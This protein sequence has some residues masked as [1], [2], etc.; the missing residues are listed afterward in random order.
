[1]WLNIFIS[2]L[3]ILII[4]IFYSIRD[5]FGHEL[6][7]DFSDNSVPLMKNAFDVVR[8]NPGEKK[9][10]V[11][12]K[13]HSQ[14]SKKLFLSVELFQFARDCAK[15][16]KKSHQVKFF[17]RHVYSVLR[18]KDAEKVLSSSKLITKS[19]VYTFLHPFLKTG[20]LTSGGEKWFQRRKLLTPAFHFNILREYFEIF[21]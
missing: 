8:M 6:F 3:L 14:Q 10:I 21:K 19:L 11:K 5:Y 13:V 4:Y 9:K 7:K 16:F 17:G 15:T 18:A 20:L 1:M 12:I 2:I